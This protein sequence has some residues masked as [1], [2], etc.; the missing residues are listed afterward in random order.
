MSYKNVNQEN[1][2]GYAD[3]QIDSLNKLKSDYVKA[4]GVDPK[5][6]QHLEN[7]EKFYGRV[8]NMKKDNDEVSELNLSHERPSLEPQ[9]VNLFYYIK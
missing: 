2:E 3:N 1:I 4:G 8:K 6:L 5:F 9:S 7:L